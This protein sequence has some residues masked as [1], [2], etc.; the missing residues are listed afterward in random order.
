[1]K[2]ENP[3]VCEPAVHDQCRLLIAITGFLVVTMSALQDRRRILC[4]TD[5]VPLKFKAV[6]VAKQSSARQQEI[7]KIFVKQ[8]I[9][10]NA[11]GSAYLEIGD[12][13]LQCSVYGP[14]PIRGS[15]TT[16]ADLSVEARFGNANEDN[17]K[18]E[19]SIA[20]FV[21]TS[22]TPSVLLIQ[23]PKSAI[24]V[25]VTVIAIDES[26]LKSV[27]AAAVN[28]ASLA[29][30]DAGISLVDITTA[31][32]VL[33]K[34]GQ[35]LYDPET[36]RENDDIDAVASYMTAENNTIVGLWIDGEQIDPQAMDQIISH[37]QIIATQIRTLLNAVL[38][39]DAVTKH[40]PHS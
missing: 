16:Q 35:V 1:M 4:P 18:L 34:G 30:V 7:R 38:L 15:F 40:A 13:R 14:K 2:F 36:A 20:S 27:L 17:E 11:S 33:L 3:A 25:M 5:S 32:S 39:E 22:I 10:A 12:I 29:L 8:G 9:V 6:D 23:Y 31:G 19:R 37:T 28:V 26:N 21:Q 24:S